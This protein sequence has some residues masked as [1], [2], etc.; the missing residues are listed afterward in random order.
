MDLLESVDP[1]QLSH[2]NENLDILHLLQWVKITNKV[3]FLMPHA[4][5]GKGECM[6][7][8]LGWTARLGDHRA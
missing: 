8:N 2:I 3:K 6:Q 1:F 4:K 5:Q 7:H